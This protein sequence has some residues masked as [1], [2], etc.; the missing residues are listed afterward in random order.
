MA[1]Q[2]PTNEFRLQSHRY[3]WFS[4]AGN[5]VFFRTIEM[6]GAFTYLQTVQPPL[7]S[8]DNKDGSL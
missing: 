7:A 2:R 6:N 1:L 4:E 5:I 8:S 3:T